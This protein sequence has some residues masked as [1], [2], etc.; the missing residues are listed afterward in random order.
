MG[1][2]LGWSVALGV[3]VALVLGLHHAGV[4]ITTGVAS[5]IRAVEHLLGVPLLPP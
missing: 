1:A 4:D 5:A 2:F 3:A